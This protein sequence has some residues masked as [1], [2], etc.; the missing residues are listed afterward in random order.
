MGWVGSSSPPSSI[1][2]NSLKLSLKVLQLPMQR[3]KENPNQKQCDSRRVV[4]SPAPLLGDLVT[5]P[6]LSAPPP[7]IS[8]CRFTEPPAPRHS[9]CFH[10]SLVF[11]QALLFRCCQDT[12]IT[13]YAL[14]QSDGHGRSLLFY[15][16][17]QVL[18][19]NAPGSPPQQIRKKGCVTCSW[20][21][22]GSQTKK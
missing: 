7:S 2:E 21:L 14:F 13:V 6:S 20:G 16:Y 4:I 3:L 15:I 10:L 19:L 22:L 11:P 9:D 5:V 8:L 18:F 17:L 1:S 12:L